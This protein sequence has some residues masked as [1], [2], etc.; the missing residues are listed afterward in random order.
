[1]IGI[2]A[3]ISGIIASLLPETLN[4]N[5]PQTIEDGDKFGKEFKYF[6]LAKITGQK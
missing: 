6:S 3:I 2:L 1:M 4:E 5:L